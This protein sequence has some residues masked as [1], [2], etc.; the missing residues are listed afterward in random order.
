MTISTVISYCSNDQDFIRDVVEKVRPFSTEISISFST[1]LFSGEFEDH[2][3]LTTSLEQ[4]NGTVKVQFPYVHG[5]RPTPGHWHNRARAYGYQVLTKP[6]DWILFLDGDE[7]VDTLEFMKWLDSPLFGYHTGYRFLGHWYFRDTCWQATSREDVSVL[8]QAS[9][10]NFQFLDNCPGERLGLLDPGSVSNVRG[11][12]GA[13]MFH[14][15]SW[16]RTKEGMLTKVRSWGHKN[17]QPWEQM[18]NYHFEQHPEFNESLTDFVHGYNFRKV[19][20]F[21]NAHVT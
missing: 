10:C 8:A 4:L 6:A 16:A 20:P 3:K 18:I 12:D 2:Q 7:V 9:K 15:Y 11:V 19:E 1:H 13:L 14:H 5:E 17:D 21:I